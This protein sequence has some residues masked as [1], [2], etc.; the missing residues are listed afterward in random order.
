[1]EILVACC[2]PGDHVK[3]NVHSLAMILTLTV[4]QN[5]SQVYPSLKNVFLHI[6][7]LSLKSVYNKP[8]QDH[9]ELFE[10]PE[11]CTASSLEKAYP[12]KMK[13]D[14]EVV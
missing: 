6:T 1:V 9:S 4:G 7:I 8:L 3:L 5:M 10:T 14:S 11:N 2:W 12:K 13:N